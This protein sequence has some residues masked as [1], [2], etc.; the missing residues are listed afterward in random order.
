[1]AFFCFLRDVYMSFLQCN[2]LN[3]NVVY[4]SRYGRG[5]MQI[6]QRGS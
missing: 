2:G 6:G 1:M 3:V 5:L 4:Y